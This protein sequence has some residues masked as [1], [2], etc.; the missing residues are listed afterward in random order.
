M[1]M[2]HI[3]LAE[4]N[5]A[6]VMLVR[7]SLTEHGIEHK[8]DVV[9]DG[10]KAIEYV[11]RVG[12]AGETQCPDVVLLDLNLPKA[13]G[14][15]VLSEVRKNP[16][17]RQTPVIIVTSS[18]SPTDRARVTELGISYYFRKPITL[19]EFMRLGAVVRDVVG[20]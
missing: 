13:D 11:K 14:P 6:D 17:C 2:L 18:D 3:L 15:Q 1:N 4:D 8:L 16:E 7:Q 12:K 19:T 10:E 20:G 9:E 5:R